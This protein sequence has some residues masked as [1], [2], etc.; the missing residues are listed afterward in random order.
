M[1]TS[2]GYDPLHWARSSRERASW[3]TRAAACASDEVGGAKIPDA[4]C[5][6]TEA[7][8]LLARNT[9]GPELTAL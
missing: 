3:D 7:Q 8:L 6:D 2:N 9:V 4:C 5:P 1:C